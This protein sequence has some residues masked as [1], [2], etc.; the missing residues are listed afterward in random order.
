MSSQAPLQ[1]GAGIAGSPQG[2]AILAAEDAR[3]PTPQNLAVLVSGTGSPN[4]DLQRAAIRA[5]GRLERRDLVSTL[6]PHLRHASATVRR[7]ASFAIAQAMRGENL[8]ADIGGSQVDGVLGALAGAVAAETD[9][10]SLREL[11]RSVAR[12]PFERAEQVNRA[13]A[14][15]RQVL[16]L[17]NELSIVRKKQGDGRFAVAGGVAAAELL[18]RLDFKLSPPSEDLIGLL[19]SHVKGQA[20]GVSRS[21]APPPSTALQALVAARGVD[22]DTLTFSLQS[23]D[24]HLRRIAVTLLGAAASPI[25]GQDRA[26]YL[27]KAMSDRAFFV[28]YEAVRGY[29]RTHAKSDGCAP[30]IDM[31]NDVNPHVALAAIDSLGDGCLGDDNA[32]L[33]IV[34]EARTPPNRGPWHREAHALVALAKLS[35]T[36]AQIPLQ[37]Q[38]RHLVW[39]VR[40]YAARAPHLKK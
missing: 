13:E 20:P 25:T 15:V 14:L 10:A 34:A 19:R 11:I 32:V 27:R 18:A 24:D 29:A 36:H 8:P 39:Q 38:T 12:L 17:S 1:E 26:A 23:S 35:P 3:A 7:E 30:L 16:T 2:V 5:L 31:L 21:D 28:R 4:P 22:Q 33:R 9:S 40:M 6:L 37:S